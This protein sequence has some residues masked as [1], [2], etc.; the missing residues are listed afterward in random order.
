MHMLLRATKEAMHYEDDFVLLKD[1][2]YISL[3]LHGVFIRR[4]RG[5]RQVA[6]A[7]NVFDHAFRP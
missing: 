7:D 2:R 3:L 5:G 4:A 6:N 1:I